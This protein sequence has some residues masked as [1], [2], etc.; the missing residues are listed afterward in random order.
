MKAIGYILCTESSRVAANYI[1][2]V[3]K[4]ENLPKDSYSLKQSPAA[5]VLFV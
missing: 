3:Q 4:K 1:I 5:C 2:V